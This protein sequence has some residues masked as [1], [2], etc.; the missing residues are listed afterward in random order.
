MVRL[1]QFSRADIRWVR[2]S[3]EDEARSYSKE[4]MDVFS[5]VYRV[6]GGYIA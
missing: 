4:E 6:I 5:R 1:D 2:D 3:N